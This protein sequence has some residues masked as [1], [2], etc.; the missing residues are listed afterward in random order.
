MI[1]LLLP[2]L[3]LIFLFQ[4]CSPKFKMYKHNVASRYEPVN[5]VLLDTRS[6]GDSLRIFLQF[7]NAQQLKGLTAPAVQIVYF[8]KPNYNDDALLMQDTV[9]HLQQKTT[10]FDDV[11]LLDFTIPK[12][13]LKP[14]A[15]LVLQIN[16]FTASES[17]LFLDVPLTDEL[18]RKNY[19]LRDYSS[20]RPLFCNYSQSTES[21]LVDRFGTQ[22][23][24][25]AKQYDVQYDPALPPMSMA[26]EQT[27]PTL[28]V[29]QKL[30]FAPQEPVFLPEQGLYLL[31]LSD[32]TQTGMLIEDGSFPELNTAEELIEPLIYLTTSDERRKLYQ[33][34]D[35]KMA[36]DNFWLEI[37]GEKGL[38]RQLI[39]TYYQRVAAANKLFSSHK[40]GWKTDRGMIYTVLGVPHEVH[41]FQN[42]EEWIYHGT[43]RGS[44]K[45]IFMKKPNT[46]TQYHY[47]LIRDRWFE[48]VWYSK[49][50]QWRNGILER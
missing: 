43:I 11:A 2:F 5:H 23:P 29:K 50:E 8:V 38:A 21:F 45:F 1:R 14:Q 32:K 4:A 34:E 25:V 48:P 6:E 33:A 9:R 13:K 44:A 26:G 40:A 24:L 41:R 22:L 16:S 3:C 35:P 17:H 20:R 46:F 19:V 18:F 10:K 47:E 27:P 37:A 39:R 7:A 28:K 42:R 12:S 15:L 31:E 36:L 49:V 30:P